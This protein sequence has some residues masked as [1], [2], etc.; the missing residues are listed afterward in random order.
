MDFDEL[1]GGNHY[2]EQLLHF[3]HN[4]NSNKGAGY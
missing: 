2:H 4:W 1:M 3:G